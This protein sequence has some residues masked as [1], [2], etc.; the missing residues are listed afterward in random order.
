MRILNSSFDRPDEDPF[1]LNGVLRN[2]WILGEFVVLNE[3]L[4]PLNA[5]FN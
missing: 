5:L 3:I 1:S 2:G 4:P